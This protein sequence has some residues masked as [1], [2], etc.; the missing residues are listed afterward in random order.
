MARMSGIEFPGSSCQLSV[1]F[2]A[3]ASAR[4]ARRPRSRRAPPARV[5]GRD[6]ERPSSRCRRSARAWTLTVCS[7]SDTV[8]PL[9]RID[10][11]SRTRS[12]IRTIVVRSAPSAPTE[13]IVSPNERPIRRAP[14][15][16]VSASPVS[17]VSPRSDDQAAPLSRPQSRSNAGCGQCFLIG[18]GRPSPRSW[19]TKRHQLPEAIATTDWRI[20][21]LVNDLNH[22]D[23][24]L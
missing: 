18:Y 8:R 11:C 6:P 23:R 24:T 7:S 20:S 4:R 2:S 5:R 17:G 22:F 12:F 10:I 3:S 13:I 14:C 15:A 21:R 16:M 19:S 9:K 1:M